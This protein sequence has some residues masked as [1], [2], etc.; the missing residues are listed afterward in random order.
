MARSAVLLRSAGKPPAATP[1]HRRAWR[2]AATAREAGAG[3]KLSAKD[4][5]AAP[6]ETALGEPA[7]VRQDRRNGG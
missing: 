7:P 4:V 2:P 3:G 5:A 1:R 6:D